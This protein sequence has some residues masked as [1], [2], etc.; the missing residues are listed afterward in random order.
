VVLKPLV[1]V[2]EVALKPDLAE[3]M[4]LLGETSPILATFTPKVV[5]VTILGLVLKFLLLLGEKL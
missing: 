5:E 2:A 4:G 1:L 3:E